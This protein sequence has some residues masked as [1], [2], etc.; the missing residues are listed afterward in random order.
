MTNITDRMTAASRAQSEHLQAIR[1]IG[2]QAEKRHDRIAAGKGAISDDD[3]DAAL[4]A[5]QAT[6]DFCIAAA[7]QG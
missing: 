3:R 5:L 2:I 1:A 6:A 7:G 4:G